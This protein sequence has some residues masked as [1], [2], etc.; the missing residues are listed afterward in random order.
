MDDKIL[1]CRLCPRECNAERT[2]YL[3]NGFC[4]MGTNPVVARIAPHYWEEPCISGKN[5]SGTIFFAGCT[6][7][8]VFCQNTKISK[9]NFGK[10]ITPYELAEKYK[11]LESIGVNNINLVTPTHF[12]SAI[13]KSIEIYKPKIPIVY[14]T[15]GYEK[16]DIIK[17]L[18]GYIDIYLPDFKYYNNEI[19]FKYSGVKNYFENAS[20][21]ISE[22]IRQTGKPVFNQNNIILRGT[23]IRH[24]ILPLNT[25]NSI[26]VLTY[27][28]QE[29][30]EN[31]LVSLMAQYTPM[32]Q[33]ER[34]PEINRKITQREYD[35]V[36]A[37]LEKLNIDGFIQD[38]KSAKETYIPN[39]NLEGV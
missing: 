8:C 39:F 16:P 36:L 4:K 10:S 28:S 29:Y 14:N 23:I 31:V 13:I 9:E 37:H 38:R 17:M 21:A 7:G 30:G 3:G 22:M 5:G 35:K 34:F 6:L 19:A 25:K 2:E 32:G 20:L 26:D 24:L 33:A 12:S 1:N 11:Y 18:N 27:I 15:G